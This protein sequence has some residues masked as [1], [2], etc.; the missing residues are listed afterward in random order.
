MPATIGSEVGLYYDSPRRVGVGD[1]LQT[2][3]G[4]TYLIQKVRVQ[5][6]GEYAGVRQHLRAI[7]ISR[8]EVPVD[9]EVF[10]IHWYARGKR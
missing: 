3:T 6:R 10:P 1:C 9:A 4:R 2:P 5:E 8:E 7:V